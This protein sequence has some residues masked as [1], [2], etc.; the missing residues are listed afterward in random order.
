MHTQEEGRVVASKER[1]VFARNLRITINKSHLNQSQIAD[2]L[3]VSRGT[4]SDYT[5]GKAFPRPEKLK[6]LCE[7][8]GVSQYDLTTDFYQEEDRF[9][10][11]KELLALAKEIYE[12]PDARAIYTQIKALDAE[13][14]KA[15][16]TLL[17][18]ISEK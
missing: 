14:V 4:V 3:G 13:G 17:S 8:L 15:F 9:V 7:I 11:N 6:Q 2:R 12:N 16:R 10:P 18:K 5:T 1:E